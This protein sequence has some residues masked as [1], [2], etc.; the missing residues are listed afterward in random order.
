MIIYHTERGI[1]MDPNKVKCQADVVIN[2]DV[3]ISMAGTAAMEVEGVA[4]LSPQLT[5]L[6]GIIRKATGVA[7]GVSVNHKDG[8]TVL[9]VYVC[10]KADAKIITVAETI[11]KNVK[12]TIQ[13]MTGMAVTTVNVHISDVEIKAETEKE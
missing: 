10:V 9:D 3:L 4:G 5:N 12:K 11:Q 2:D 13:D 7:G 6:R 1:F 8:D